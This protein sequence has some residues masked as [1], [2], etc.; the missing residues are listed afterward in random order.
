MPLRTKGGLQPTRHALST[1]THPPILNVLIEMEKNARSKYTINFTSKALEFL[2]KHADLNQPEQVKAFIAR[3]TSADGYKR[4]LCIAYNKYVKYYQLQWKMPLYHA[5]AKAIRIP[6]KE[7]LEMLIAS[8]KTPT[9]TKL[10]ISKETGLRP[11]ELCNLRV[12]DVDLEQKQ[13]YPT[14]AKNGA[15]RTPKISNSLKEAIQEHIDTRKLNPNDKLFKGDANDYG[16][17]YRNMRNALAE[18]LHDPTIKNIRLYD[19]RHYFATTLYAKT[20]DILLVKQQMGHRKI[21]TT[22]IYT[23]LLNLND[24]EWTCKAAKEPKEVMQL[25][26]AGFEYVQQIDG[27]NLYRKRK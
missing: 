27:L 9:S 19:F 23:Q 11:V 13:I 7:K 14:T 5:E 10:R 26:E 24:D 21:E 6:T 20:R 1:V 18:K 8:A 22:L 3:L 4:N 17:H 2:A 25:I 15:G 12:K 16:K